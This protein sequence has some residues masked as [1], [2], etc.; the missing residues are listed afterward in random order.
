VPAVAA[1]ESHC[2]VLI[3]DADLAEVIPVER[4]AR[5]IDELTAPLLHVGKGKLEAPKGFPE[6]ALGL[7]VIKGL[8][9]RRVAVD[10]RPGA[11]L[12]GE[13]DLLRPWQSDEV[14]TLPMTSEWS[15]LAPARLAVLDDTFA[16]H[17]ANYP[18]LA[19]R[20]VE[21]AVRR[22]R[23]LVIN[24]AI[25]HDARVDERLRMLFWH[26]AARWGRVRGDGVVLPL[27]LTHAVLAELVAARR[28]TVTS[29]LSELSRQ[30]VVEVVSD[31][32]L[33]LG[34]PPSDSR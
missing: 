14:P 8:L 26:L 24:M 5:A 18:E 3:E 29:A 20:L 10:G 15:V 16:R 33:L 30:G 19:S 17:L 7:L 31:G 22:S 2:H 32:W 13:C 27:P 9:L 21:R 12:L 11:E 34:S 6:H 28:P 25:V 4:R 1:A 23:R